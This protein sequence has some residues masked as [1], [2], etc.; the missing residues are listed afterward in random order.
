MTVNHVL[1]RGYH[2]FIAVGTQRQS[3]VRP[4]C[5]I[6]SCIAD[7]GPSVSVSSA[8]YGANERQGRKGADVLC[9][10]ELL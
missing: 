7:H 1:E 10:Q 4:E 3:R 2:E 5:P 9:P 8:C 6:G